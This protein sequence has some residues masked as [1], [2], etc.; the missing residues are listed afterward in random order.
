[1][2]QGP[3]LLL[4]LVCLIN[5]FVT[6]LKVKELGTLGERMETIEHHLFNIRLRLSQIDPANI[7][8]LTSR[9]LADKPRKPSGSNG[10]HG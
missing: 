10:A 1:M 5:A 4:S 8:R 2:E 7:N 3:I 6:A 9:M